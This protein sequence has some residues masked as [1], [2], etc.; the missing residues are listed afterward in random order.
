MHPNYDIPSV[1]GVTFLPQCLG[2]RVLV[3]DSSVSNVKFIKAAEAS[4]CVSHACNLMAL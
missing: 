4:F 1:P 2:I 3:S